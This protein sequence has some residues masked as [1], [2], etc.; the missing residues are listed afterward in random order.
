VYE[1]Q[2]WLPRGLMW[3]DHALSARVAVLVLFWRVYRHHPDFD[4]K[5][6]MT[7]FELVDRSGQLLARL[8]LFTFFSNHGVM[9]NLALAHIAVAF[10]SLPGA[11]RYGRVAAERLQEQL[12]FYMDN[13]GVVLEHS[14][15]YQAFGV[16]LLGAAMR[17]LTLLDRPIPAGWW[18]KYYR[19]RDVYAELRRPD[20]SLPPIGD[21]N[22]GPDPERPITHRGSDGQ[23]MPLGPKPTVWRPGKGN[24]LYAVA[25][26]AVWWDGLEHW[27]NAAMA[28]TV[29]AWSYFPGHAHKHAD[30]T[31]V[32][33]WAEGQTWWTNVG[34]WLYIEGREEALSWAG[35]NA[36][37]LAG[38]WA[39]SR[40]QAR[41]LQISNDASVRFLELE[42]R[43][44]KSALR[45]QVLHCPPDLWLVLDDFT[46][47][48]PVEE[49]W[50]SF[51]DVQIE[52]TGTGRAYRLKSRS[53]KSQ[54]QVY[55][56]GSKG[57]DCE[58][59]SRELPP[60]CGLGGGGPPTTSC[61][62]ATHSFSG[63][64]GLVC[65]SVV[66]AGGRQRKTDLSGVSA[67]GI[68]DR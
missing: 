59:L 46:A 25:G 28:Q 17:A 39:D 31:S 27:P 9:Q 19:A 2:A 38:E 22:P 43:V 18:G 36:P 60:I 61:A 34:P 50:T 67:D 45:R 15:G 40:R 41:L 53:G 47:S 1:R 49:T 4:P 44:G 35:S 29:V 7:V 66:D 62:G 12:D 37:R 21:T 11:N 5:V 20:G 52:S 54:L 58:E 65:C 64:R 63:R 56:L 26:Y 23:A 14:P 6:A 33:F 42:R 10:P 24:A 32:L 68:M 51:P 8:Q 16:A 55:F 3:N 30:E 13:E 48:A 57:V